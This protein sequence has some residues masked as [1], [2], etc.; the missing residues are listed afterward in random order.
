MRSDGGQAP[1]MTSRLLVV[2][3]RPDDF[4]LQEAKCFSNT[5]FNRNFLPTIMTGFI[6]RK[7]TI[8]WK[9]CND[10]RYSAGV[11][12][13]TSRLGD[14]GHHLPSFSEL[15]LCVSLSSQ[16]VA[17]VLFLRCRNKSLDFYVPNEFGSRSIFRFVRK[18]QR[19][20][21]QALVCK[22]VFFFSRSI[23]NGRF[24]STLYQ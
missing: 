18:R 7:L 14:S 3:G 22:K 2:S 20:Q 17:W 11:C 16:E 23:V 9:L 21:F 24:L 1:L 13:V 8:T 10:L 6:W 15:F 19:R 12:F 4:P 5:I